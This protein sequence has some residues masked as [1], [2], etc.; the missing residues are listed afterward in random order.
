[1]QIPF[2]LGSFIQD[3]VTNIND[4]DEVVLTAS[5]MLRLKVLALYLNKAKFI[6]IS[7]LRVLVDFQKEYV[8]LELSAVHFEE[9][10]KR[11]H[12]LFGLC[13]F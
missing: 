2:T 3:F 8:V 7:L 11:K 5:L 1:M 6:F 10:I 13:N 12:Q 9:V 4:F